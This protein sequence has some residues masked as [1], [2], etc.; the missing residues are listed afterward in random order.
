MIGLVRSCKDWLVQ[1]M[2]IYVTLD[3]VRSLN[4]MLFQCISRKG[5][6][7]LVRSCYLRLCHIAAYARL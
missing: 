3:Q 1:V 4:D 7:D 2:P 5:M 6:L